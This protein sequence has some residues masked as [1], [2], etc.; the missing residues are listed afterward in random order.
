MVMMTP[1]DEYRNCAHSKKLHIRVV[2]YTGSSKVLPGTT[3]YDMHLELQIRCTQCACADNA[4]M[5]D[6]E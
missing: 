2:E 3:M 4:S 5:N 6:S 1:S